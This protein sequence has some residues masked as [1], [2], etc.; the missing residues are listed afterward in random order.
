MNVRV[1]P[2]QLFFIVRLLISLDLQQFSY[3]VSNS[4]SERAKLE[5][6][7][8]TKVSHVE[9]LLQGARARIAQAQ[10]ELAEGQADVKSL[11]QQLAQAIQ[12]A[13]VT[14][15]MHHVKHESLL[16]AQEEVQAAV[17]EADKRSER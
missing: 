14:L 16:A 17:R 15:A 8:D 6:D 13:V 11:Q 4:K 9:T 1:Y 10:L 2:P 12:V 3:G 7:N 5:K